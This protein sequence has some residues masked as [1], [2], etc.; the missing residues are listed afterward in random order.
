MKSN[1]YRLSSFAKT[2]DGGNPAGVVLEADQLSESEMKQI[3]KD[4]GYSETAFVMK[5]NIAD[6]RVRFF[7]P[8]E[9][10]DLC[11]HATIATFNLLRD[12]GRITPGNYSQETK[13]G[14]LRLQI[15]DDEVFMEQTLPI[16]DQILSFEEIKECFKSLEEDCLDNLPIQIVSTGLR[17]IILPIKHLKLLN[18]LKPNHEK[19]IEI[20]KKYNAI[21]I[22]AFSFESLQKVSGHC[23]N[24]APFYGINEESATGTANG[25]LACYIS[26]YKA[27]LQDQFVFEQGYHML[28]PSEIK[29]KIKFVAEE[30]VALYVGGNAIMINGF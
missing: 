8:V 30:L 16:F 24:F 17:D 1:I 11:G 2:K 28:R 3:A 5:S 22:H 10:V 27:H 19:I 21:G 14:V 26:K 20:S 18:G 12:L 13:A 15:S 4:V 7:T 6:F 9:E 25:A 29:V 23:R